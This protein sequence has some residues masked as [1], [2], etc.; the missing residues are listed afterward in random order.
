MKLRTKLA[1]AISA[2][3]LTGAVSA[4]QLDFRHEWKGETKQQA[5]RVKLSSGWKLNSDWTTNVGVEMKFAGNNSDSIVDPSF[6]YE[7]DE[8]FFTDTELTETELD[9]GLTYK[10][11]SN[12]QIKPGMPIAMTPRKVTFKPQLRV[13]Y[14]ADF[15]LTTALR[16][17]HEFASYSDLDDGDTSMKT[18][19]KVNNPQKS[20]VTLTGGYKVKA[21]PNLKLSYEAN[22]VKSLDNVKQFD[23]ED[24]EYD[25]G[26]TVGYQL[27]N[28]RP[29]AEIWNSDVSSST[30]ERQAKYRA[31]IKYKF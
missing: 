25:Y 27:G 22:Y 26:V 24:W 13:V 14:K 21:L 18:G 10:V 11:N 9:L 1:L 19:E 12:W 31:G 23:G 28:W 17:R 3:L 20:K 2:S 8:E 29:Y 5:S 16:Y 6:E 30:D 4:S 15:G 7:S